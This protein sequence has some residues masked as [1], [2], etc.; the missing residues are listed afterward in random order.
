LAPGLK[1]KSRLK[2]TETT[3]ETQ[4]FPPSVTTPSA[5]WL[6]PINAILATSGARRPTRRTHAALLA[7]IKAA[8][9]KIKCDVSRQAVPHHKSADL[10]LAGYPALALNLSVSALAHTHTP[11]KNCSSA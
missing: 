6:T 3:K 2:W 4:R 11:L 9:G 5:R 7:T 10:L 1:K 8:K